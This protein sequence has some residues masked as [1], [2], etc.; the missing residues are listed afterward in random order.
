MN[1]LSLDRVKPTELVVKIARTPSP[2]RLLPAN[3]TLGRGQRWTA[4]CVGAAT[5]N[6][7]PV[8]RGKMQHFYYFAPAAK[9]VQ[10]AGCF[11]GWQAQPIHL[12]KLASGMWWTAVVT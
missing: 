4:D 1:K 10:L 6:R 2:F 12:R 3:Q 7:E 8:K 11:T 9:S 5:R